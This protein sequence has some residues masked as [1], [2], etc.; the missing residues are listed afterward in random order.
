MRLWH[1]ALITKLPNQMLVAQWR[2]LAAIVGAIDKKGSPNHRLVNIILDY[3][4]AHLYTYTN[5]VYQ[6]LI[7]RNLH[8][9]IKVYHKITNYCFSSEVLFDELFKDWHNK[10]YY[11]Q[12]YYNLEEKY[13]RGIIN[14]QDWQKI[15]SK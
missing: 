15:I 3:D 12:C 5:L 7:K 2:E 14:E 11:Q 1:K 10:R 4:K 9:Q 6:E 8:P 13:D